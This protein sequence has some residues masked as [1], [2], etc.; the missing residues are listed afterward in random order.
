MRKIRIANE[1]G[2]DATVAY[3]TL[4]ASEVPELGLPGETVNF[5]RY[6]SAAPTGLHESLVATHGEDYAQALVD[7]DPEVD[8][9]VV[10]RALGPTDEV[11]LDHSGQVIYAP[12]EV[13]EVLL[14]PDGSEAERRAPEDCAARVDRRGDEGCDAERAA[15]RRGN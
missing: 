1:T 7:G 13:V 11:L 2:R 15:W 12:P 4:R 8:L 10:G 9:E 5:R 3:E 6:L 14:N